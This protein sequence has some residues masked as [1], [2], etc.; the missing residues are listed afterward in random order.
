MGILDAEPT[1]RIG[2]RGRG[3]GQ[4]TGYLH[5][6]KQQTTTS[7]L[8]AISLSRG[9]QTSAVLLSSGFAQSC[10][11]HAQ[12]L[13]WQRLTCLVAGVSPN[14]RNDERRLAA[15]VRSN[16]AEQGDK[17]TKP[18]TAI[19]RRLHAISNTPQSADTRD[20]TTP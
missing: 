11:P 19:S 13:I 2:D 4:P 12:A 7:H 15:K 1:S 18:T 16:N 5:S 8:S 20:W 3:Q 14:K 17:A 10:F 9:A 6:Q